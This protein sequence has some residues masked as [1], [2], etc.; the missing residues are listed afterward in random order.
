MSGRLKFRAWDKEN[1]EMTD[2]MSIT[3]HNGQ[4][5]RSKLNV[6]ENYIIMQ[7]TGLKDKNG[8]LIYEGD[9]IED[10]HGNN[11]LV[12]FR[13]RSFVAVHSP[14]TRSEMEGEC[15][16]DYLYDFEVHTRPEI[17][18]KIYENPELVEA[19]NA[20]ISIRQRRNSNVRCRAILFSR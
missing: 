16:W 2:S 20:N 11:Y 17:I 15:K 19:N 12:D 13:N 8:K 6:T 1:K 14:K 5:Y 4:I 7:C 3:I 9:I 18:G 10:D